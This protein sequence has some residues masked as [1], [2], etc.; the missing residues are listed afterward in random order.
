MNRKEQILDAA[1]TNSNYSCPTKAFI[2]GAFWADQ[3]SKT[4]ANELLDQ[5]SNTIRNILDNTTDKVSIIKMLN[6]LDNF[7]MGRKE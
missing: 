5:A 7:A 6:K 4:G 2:E 3:N 1:M